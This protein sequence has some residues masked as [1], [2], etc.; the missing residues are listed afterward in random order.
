MWAKREELRAQR[1]FVPVESTFSFHTT[2]GQDNGAPQGMRAVFE[3]TETVSVVLQPE[4]E[5]VNV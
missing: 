3:K 5:T 2:G 1:T 4:R